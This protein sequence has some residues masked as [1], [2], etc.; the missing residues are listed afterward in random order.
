MIHKPDL[1]LLDHIEAGLGP[2]LALGVDDLT[3]IE[4]LDLHM[5]QEKRFQPV[6]QIHQ[7]RGGIEPGGLT[8]LRN[9]LA[10]EHARDMHDLLHPGELVDLVLHLKR[11]LLTLN[12]VSLQIFQ[13]Q[14]Q[15]SVPR[16]VNLPPKR[17]FL[18]L[19]ATQLPLPVENPQLA[20]SDSNFLGHAFQHISGLVD[21]HTLPFVPHEVLCHGAMQEGVENNAAAHQDNRHR[22]LVV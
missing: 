1:A 4:R 11:F 12:R 9:H 15:N 16:T 2:R 13:L 20:A 18:V 21:F 7:K 19:L 14:S 5:V 10:D 17:L 3:G 6:R 8:V 22:I